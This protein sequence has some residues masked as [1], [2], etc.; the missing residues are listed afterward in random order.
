MMIK[1][2]GKYLA[3]ATKNVLAPEIDTYIFATIG[4]AI[5]TGA[6]A[7]NTITG[8]TTSANA[9]TNFTNLT[10]ALTDGEAPE[11][12]RVAAV[13]PAFYNAFKQSGTLDASD[14][15]LKDRKSGVAGMID[16]VKIVIVPS[17]RMPADTD[18]IIGHPD[19]V[20][21]PETQNDDERKTYSSTKRPKQPF[22]SPS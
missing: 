4:T 2:A 12:G 6:I 8:A 20:C 14:L 16:G 9:Y 15:G 22:P 13:T 11:E 18:V 17:T 5:A 1:Q 19:A 7:A 3:Q 10:A 21:A